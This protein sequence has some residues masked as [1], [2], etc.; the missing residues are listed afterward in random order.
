MCFGKKRYLVPLRRDGKDIDWVA[1]WSYL[2]VTLKTHT[3]FNCCIDEK[4][5]SFYWSANGLLRIE[6]RF[7]ETV[8][9]QLMETHCLPILTYAINTISV[10]DQDERRR[11]RVAFTSTRKSFNTEHGNMSQSCSFS[12]PHGRN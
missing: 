1:S 9:L 4:V 8:M 6:G 10:A 11:L 12:A 2:G 5:K 7:S 3:S